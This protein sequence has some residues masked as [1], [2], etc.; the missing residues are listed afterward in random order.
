[1]ESGRL[2]KT[3]RSESYEIKF[4]A[5]VFAAA[6]NKEDILEPLVDRF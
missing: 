4:T 5:W 6:N 3:T 1:M 2:K